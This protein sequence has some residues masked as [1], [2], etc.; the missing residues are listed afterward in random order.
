[1]GVVLSGFCCTTILFLNKINRLYGMSRSQFFDMLGLRYGTQSIQKMEKVERAVS[2]LRP[3]FCQNNH[4]N[5][6]LGPQLTDFDILK[7]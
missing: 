6:F 1:M 7:A 5:S 2:D 4:K 3:F